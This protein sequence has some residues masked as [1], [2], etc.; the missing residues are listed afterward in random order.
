M[1][2]G[3]VVAVVASSD[4][5]IEVSCLS[6]EKPLVANEFSSVHRET[7]SYQLASL[8]KL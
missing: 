6:R 3:R 7:S 5:K 4:G 8:S 1:D 2:D